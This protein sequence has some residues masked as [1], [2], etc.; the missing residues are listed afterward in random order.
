MYP[1]EVLQLDNKECL[2]LIRGQKPL[3]GYKIIPDEISGF[4][5]LKFTRISEYVPMWRRENDSKENEEDNQCNSEYTNVEPKED[6]HRTPVPNFGT[7][8]EDEDTKEET[9]EQEVSEERD[10][11]VCVPVEE[12]IF[13]P[14]N[15][16]ETVAEDILNE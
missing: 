5:E 6:T 16:E 15:Y 11:A 3:K 9:E 8:T 12:S 14:D 4:K 10:T 7:N 2:L 13:D 1:E